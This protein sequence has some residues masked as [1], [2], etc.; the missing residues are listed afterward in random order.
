MLLDTKD[1]FV[2]SGPTTTG[3]PYINEAQIGAISVSSTF[4]SDK[5]TLM[6]WI[7]RTPE[8]IGILNQ[9]AS[10]IVT[11]INFTSRETQTMGRPAKNRSKNNVDKA[12]E[13]ARNNFLKQTLKAAVIDELALG[14][15][16]IWKGKLNKKDFDNA[17]KS[18]LKEIG[19]KDTEIKEI[20][21]KDLETLDEDFNT[22]RTLEYVPAST[23]NIEIH[24]SGTYV[25]S[26]VQRT[27]WTFGTQTFPSRRQDSSQPGSSVNKTR[28]WKPENIIHKKFME[29]DGK[30]HGFT[31]MQ[32][33]FPVMKTLGLIKDYHGHW[34]D[35]GIKPDTIFN[36]EE[37]DANSIEFEKMRQVLQEWHNNRRRSHVVTTSKMN[38][39]ELNQWNKDMEFRLLAIYYTGVMAFGMGM[40]IEKIRAILGSEIK[41]S[42]GGSD[43]GNIDYQRNIFDRQDDWET[44]MNTQFF[45]EEFD[46]D[47]HFDRSAARDEIAEV[48]RDAQKLNNIEKMQQMDLLKKDKLVAFVEQNFPSIPSSWWNPNPKPEVMMG[49]IPSAGAPPKGPA[50][51][52][53]SDQKKAEQK[54]QQKNN[55][56]TGKELMNDFIKNYRGKFK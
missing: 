17:V 8:A 35:A 36:F 18:T 46:V 22:E 51:Q 13:F 53:L 14:D 49:Q 29:L 44:L 48:Q 31:P 52:A 6:N 30:V 7:K 45:N 40:P 23:M 21:T 2:I 1:V 42:T 27:A 32:S 39:Q 28:R 9:L 25:E 43:L 37:M 56:P 41:S 54:P 19:V 20:M 50:S 33:I 16:Y 5:R 12:D 4:L 3:R 11:K 10:D 15:G 47:M 34:F 24:Q 26:F 55:P 38:V